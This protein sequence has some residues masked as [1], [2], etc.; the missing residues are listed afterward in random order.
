MHF[1]DWAGSGS[2]SRVLYM[3]N[4]L[5]PAKIHVSTVAILIHVSTVAILFF[6]LNDR[7]FVCA[8]PLLHAFRTG[9]HALEEGL[10][11]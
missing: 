3:Y 6:H 7:G 10:C 4:T 5:H 8:F 1:K 9:T 2:T 11:G